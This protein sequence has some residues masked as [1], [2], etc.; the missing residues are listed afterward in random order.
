MPRFK[1]Q[2]RQQEQAAGP[3][4]HQVTYMANSKDGAKQ[5]RI[6]PAFGPAKNGQL[7]PMSW[8]PFE[9]E[10]G[11]NTPWVLDYN[12][13]TNIGHGPWG[14]AGNRRSFIDFSTWFPGQGLFDPVQRVV[15]IASKHKEWWYLFDKMQQNNGREDSILRR[16]PATE[17]LA[18]VVIL[19]ATGLPKTV[20]GCFSAS[21]TRQ[22]CGGIT[23]TGETE[24][25]ILSMMSN[26]PQEVIEKNPYLKYWLGDV[27]D[28]NS[29][30]VL[31]I[32]RD[33]SRNPA[34][35][36]IRPAKDNRGG[37]LKMA[38]TPEQMAARVDL[39]D[40]NNMA[41]PPTMQEE[42]DRLATCLNEWSPDHKY[43][44]YELLKLA[45]EDEG[46]NVPNPPARGS[47]NGFVPPASAETMAPQ[48]QR[49]AYPHVAQPQPQEPQSTFA[50]YP[51]P[52]PAPAAPQ[53][54]VTIYPAG[55]GTPEQKGPVIQRAEATW[56]G[57]GQTETMD[58][59]KQ[60]VFTKITGQTR[61]TVVQ[62]VQPKPASQVAN[63]PGQE[64]PKYDN[65][66]PARFKQQ[67]SGM[68]GPATSFGAPDTQTT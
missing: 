40:P 38:V 24:P 4:K 67:M 30:V 13:W 49:V 50:P 66:N 32:Y 55:Y 16:K 34:P 52:Q 7:D 17:L 25:G 19:T 6:L 54:N 57:P 33:E 48:T 12:V 65:F 8:I 22:L 64:I 51:A 60:S 3:F 58:Q 37:M 56:V 47:V 23:A 63:I 62:S 14:R 15:E 59:P 9:D 36:K 28:P 21:L 46:Y 5:F 42:V 10:S 2:I 26:L 35:Y 18:N 45:F 39:S 61:D 44:E 11:E 29:G 41:V 68:N 1:F 27:T 53:Q 20:V 43:H 31:E